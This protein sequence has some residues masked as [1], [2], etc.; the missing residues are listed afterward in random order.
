MDH[1]VLI[2][3]GGP[4]GL[5]MSV[6]LSR[7]GVESLLVERHSTTARHPKGRNFN[8]RSAEI[9]RLWGIE[10]ELR[11]G[12]LPEEWGGQIV[13]TRKLEG[14]ELGRMQTAGFGHAA[15]SLSPARALLSSQDLIEPT[16]RTHAERFDCAQVRFDCEMAAFQPDQAG[17]RA[18]LVD[19]VSGASSE[20]RAR[21]LVAA[22]GAAS[23]VREQL[24]IPLEGRKGLATLINVFF[25]ADLSRWTNGRPAVLYWIAEPG[26]T[27]VLQP[28]DG[29]RRWLCQIAYDVARESS[30]DYTPE[31]CAAWIRRAVGSAD[32]EIE[33]L[34]VMPWTLH[35]TVA[36]SMRAGPVFLVG[37]AAHQF[38]PTGGFGMNSGLQDAHNLAW[39]LAGAVHG[40]AGERL[41]DSYDA[42]RRPVC[43]YNVRRSLENAGMV[44]RVNRAVLEGGDAAEAVAASRR[45]GNFIG[46]DIGFAYAKGALVPDGTPPPEVGDVVIDY[47]P[48]ARPG[49]RAPHLPLERDGATLS[50]L[51]LFDMR[52][53]LLA[54]ADGAAWRDAARACAGDVPLDAWLIGQGGDLADPSGEWADVYGIGPDGAVLVRPDGHVAW[55]SASS[56]ENPRATLSSVLA[57]LLG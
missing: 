48:T 37:D 6:L 40:W 49:H 3:G 43:V 29:D 7:L 28:L 39:K 24:A 36:A 10:T 50:T 15:R 30:E 34:S 46:M 32:P 20:V 55:R 33:I 26:A 8:L 42:E 47:V 31:R 41:L 38:P 23:G 5:A 21:Y 11:K 12:S 1:S 53:T 57:R 9:V 17:V 35:A 22:D 25:H 54:A 13:F 52:F 2:V 16:I 45:Y 27:G 18:T 4:V 51:D 44:G 19:R 14:P 56:V